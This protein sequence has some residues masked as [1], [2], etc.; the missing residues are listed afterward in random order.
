MKLSYWIFAI[1]LG[2]SMAAQGQEVLSLQQC[3]EKALQYNK[4][5]AAAER[6]TQQARYT[7]KQYKALFFP[8]F[9]AGYLQHGRWLLGH[10]GRQPAH[11]RTRRFRK[12]LA[13]Q[14]L[15]L[16]SGI[17]DEV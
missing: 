10:S 6:Q 9:K 15:R 8:D 13:Q 2:S 16:F 11:F 7:E 1:A 17:G 5:I 3:R 4:Q 12:L 14:W